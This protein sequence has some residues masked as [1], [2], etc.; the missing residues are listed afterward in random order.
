MRL[1]ALTTDAIPRLPFSSRLWINS[2]LNPKPSRLDLKR[3]IHSEP[4]DRAS[5]FGGFSIEP[6]RG[7]AEFEMLMPLVLPRI[8]QRPASHP[9][10]V[11]TEQVVG[12]VV[13]AGGTGQSQIVEIIGS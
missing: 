6:R 9:V 5:A 1:V 11:D 2:Q 4:V 3:L 8:E 12:F 13:I 10:F 7:G